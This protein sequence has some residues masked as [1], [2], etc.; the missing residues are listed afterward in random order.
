M[1]G[2]FSK[3]RIYA[4]STNIVFFHLLDMQC[5]SS[6]LPGTDTEEKECLLGDKAQ[7]FCKVQINS[8]ARTTF[9]PQT[10]DSKEIVATVR[11]VF[12]LSLYSI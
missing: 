4:D 9:F 3:G 1:V 2:I 11:N 12:H 10:Q 6:K 5:P 7:R 8:S